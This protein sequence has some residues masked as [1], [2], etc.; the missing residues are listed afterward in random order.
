MNFRKIKLALTIDL[1]NHPDSHGVVHFAK[2]KMVSYK[3]EIGDFQEVM[4]TGTS[5]LG[6]NMEMRSVALQFEHATL[7]LE[8]VE[9]N[10][11]NKEYLQKFTLSE[12]N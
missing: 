4:E 6:E 8:V 3:A 2:E 11:K 12:K 9:D 5:H 10:R 1:L 7:N